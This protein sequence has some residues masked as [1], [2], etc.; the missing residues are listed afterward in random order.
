MISRIKSLL[1]ILIAIIVIGTVGFWAIEDWSILDSLYMTIIT[2]TT[3]GF[4]EVEPLDAYG[5]IFTI[6]LVIFGIASVGYA[7]RTIG[8]LILDGQLRKLIGSRKM[9]KQIKKLKDHYIVCGFGRVGGAVCGELIRNNIPFVVIERSPKAVELL[10]KNSFIFVKGDCANDENLKAAGIDRA[11]GLINTVADEADAVYIT[12]S[13]RTINPNLFIM[14]RADSQSVHNKLL[15]AGA[16][17]VISPHIAAGVRMAQATL[18]PA[19]VDFMSLA[20]NGASEG[21]KIEELV[22]KDNSKLAGTTL[23]DS[24]IRSEL[25]ITVIGIQKKGHDIY[26]SPPPDLY[27]D[28]GDTLIIVGASSQMDKLETLCSA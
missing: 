19:V 1:F 25:G 28:E 16:T 27:I 11:K 18:K 13:A 7:L 15:R 12:L 22:I 4:R 24:G 23:K 21:I 5:K 10:E 3:I 20:A 26:Y 14:A 6:L 9:E 2:L 8:Q 17:R